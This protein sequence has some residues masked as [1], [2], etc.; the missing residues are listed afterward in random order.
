MQPPLRT[1]RPRREGSGP[2]S[3]YVLLRRRGSPGERVLVRFP[4]FPRVGTCFH[5]IGGE[6]TVCEVGERGF[7]A[8]PRT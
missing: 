7:V 3:T 2:I 4:S 6:W 1:R 8:E 5:A